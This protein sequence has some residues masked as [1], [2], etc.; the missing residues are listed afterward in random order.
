MTE[1]WAHARAEAAQTANLLSSYAQAVIESPDGLELD[2]HRTRDGQLVCAHDPVLF[3]AA[4]EA[5]DIGALDYAEL[6]HYVDPRAHGEQGRVPLLDE[7]YELLRPTDI[8]LNIEAK[9]LERRYPHMAETIAA[10]VAASGMSERVVVSAFHHQLL[11]DLRA[12]APGLALAALYADGLIRPWEYLAAIDIQE[13]HPH[14]TS[15]RDAETVAGLLE[16]NLTIR[17]WTVNDEAHWR[18]LAASGVHAIITDLPVSARAAVGAPAT[19]VSRTSKLPAAEAN[20]PT[21]VAAP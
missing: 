6:R 12:A 3:D 5:W 10:S 21:L 1:I 8:Q 9:N 15:L 20:A 13:V 18:A 4:G 7:V 19:P 14:F 16:A 11:L 17:A 2:V